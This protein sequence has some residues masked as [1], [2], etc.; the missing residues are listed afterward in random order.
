MIGNNYKHDS[1]I[2]HSTGEANYLDDMALHEDTFHAAVV[3]SN[4]AHAKILKIH[5][6]KALKIPGVIDVLTSKDI[7]GVN[8]IGPIIEDEPA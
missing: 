5:T 2:L 4:Y 8:K 3:V 7:P 1:S 6:N